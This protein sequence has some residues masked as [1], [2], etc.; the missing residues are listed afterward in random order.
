MQIRRIVT[1]LVCLTLSASFEGF[2]ARSIG[3][4]LPPLNTPSVTPAYVTSAWQSA[5]L[6]PR[7]KR[8]DPQKAR[9][10]SFAATTP[11]SVYDTGGV[12]PTIVSLETD[13]NP[14]GASL[15]FNTGGGV[16]TASNAFFQVLG[17]NGR[18]CVTCHQPPSGMS[19]SVGNIDAR[20]T[21]TLGTDPIFAPVDGATC[22]GN[23]TGVGQPAVAFFLLLN[24]G[25]FRVFL[26]VPAGAQF[27][28]TVLS[29]PY[30]CNTDPTF[31]Q[32]TDPTTGATTQMVS[33][34][35]RPT[36]TAN[37]AFVNAPIPVPPATVAAPPAI[38]WDE[39]ESSLT[40]QVIDATLIHAQALT[41][42][43]TDQVNQIV[44]F[45]TGIYEAQRTDNI[46]LN[47]AGNGA[48]G[49]PVAL[50]STPAG[51]S[52]S[53]SAITAFSAWTN[54]SGASAGAR[55]ASIARGEA[56]FDSRPFVISNT[57]GLATITDA[58]CTTCH[59]QTG[60]ANDP[61]GQAFSFDDGIGGGGAEFGG[62]SPSTSLPIFQVTC[63]AGHTT[64]YA[65]STFVTNDP[66]RALIT[67]NCRD[68]EKFKAPQLRSLANRPPY[69]S[70]GSAPTLAD[71]VR[72]YDD[73]FSVGLSSQD[74]QDLVSF[75]SAL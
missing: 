51:G 40:Q 62:P 72:F 3:Q 43:T 45:E 23:V 13:S 34:Y 73:R 48:A 28:V 17:S 67:G 57:A 26:P 5:L 36:I 24:Q 59:R 21:A 1:L 7:P 58:T 38:M 37:L 25:L 15:T 54:L 20:F 64:Q 8:I 32:I 75:L 31:A 11:T 44:Q 49:G 33:V 29:D 70:D 47:L 56:I 22:P 19:V 50:A 71:V 30:G 16:I 46:A 74:Q 52:V 63:T 27:T 68:I 9:I 6:A 39:R 14:S 10:A 35:R 18:S 12:P 2:R 55:R 42:P 66:G 60:A 69:F 65:G 61:F 41:A 53:D 4:T